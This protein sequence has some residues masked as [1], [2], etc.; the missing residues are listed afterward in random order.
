MG[1]DLREIRPIFSKF[2]LFLKSNYAIITILIFPLLLF[3]INRN[4]FLINPYA[5]Y[6]D[7]WIYTGFFLNFETYYKIFGVTYYGTRLSWIIPGYLFYHIFPP[8]MA[9][10]LLHLT[11]Y[12]AAIV[13]FFYIMKNTL[14]QRVAVFT[15]ILM[16]SYMFFLYQM[17][18][19]LSS[20][21]VMAFFLLT[22]LF[23]TFSA[24]SRYWSIHLVLGGFFFIS[25]IYANFFSIIFTP[26]IIGY[27]VYTNQIRVKNP[28]TRNIVFSFTGIIIGFLVMELFAFFLT[29]NYFVLLK[30]VQ[31]AQYLATNQN[32]WYIS[33]KT[34]IFTATWLIFPLITAIGA[35]IYLAING[36][37]TLL[38]KKGLILFFI[39]NYFWF[40]G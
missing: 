16:G 4:V 29:G 11:F 36:L 37:K 35:I 8:L 40:S 31:V 6:I 14:T 9:N 19:D 15:T 17:G 1:D 7:P 18:W 23:I 2:L 33:M 32:P 38:I 30:Q 24:R 22:I 13:S 26:T 20:G 27:Y 5:Q 12:Y 25:M 21:S 39:F 3:L 28:I 34:W 10:Y